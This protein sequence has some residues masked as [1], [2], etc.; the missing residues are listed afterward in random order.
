MGGVALGGGILAR[1]GASRLSGN[2]SSGGAVGIDARGCW[3]SS[4]ADNHVSDAT[5]GLSVGGSQNVTVSQNTLLTNGWGVLATAI[6][7]SLSAMLTGPMSI[8]RNWIGFTTA[9]GGGIKVLDA[10]QGVA[11]T[12]NDING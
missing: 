2:L 6:E 9:Q 12:G 4:I 11:V 7:P 1:I 5:T 10:A 8:S 3:G